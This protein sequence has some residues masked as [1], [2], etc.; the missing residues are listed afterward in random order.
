MTQQK[1]EYKNILE[2]KAQNFKLF[3]TNSSQCSHLFITYSNGL[4]PNKQMY[5][6]KKPISKPRITIKSLI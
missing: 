4:M 2:N 1:F 3:D 5:S 6:S